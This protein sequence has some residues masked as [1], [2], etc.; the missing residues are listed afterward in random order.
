MKQ[1]TA[2]YVSRLDRDYS[3]MINRAG[4]IPYYTVDGKLYFCLAQDRQS[5]DYTDFGG[6]VRI[7][8]E[9][10]VGGAVREFKEESFRIF[11]TINRTKL[12]SC[13]A[14]I[15][16]NT[17]VIFA[18]LEPIDFDPIRN[19]FNAIKERTHYSENEDIICVS[20]EELKKLPK[21]RIFTKV[22]PCIEYICEY[23]SM[24]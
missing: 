8:K 5:G 6:G 23:P 22:L 15:S 4:I 14:V 2:G 16:G 24:L 1:V 17:M 9:D 21:D 10:C 20:L 7:S 19:K 3:N 11:G 18:K 13:P 12:R